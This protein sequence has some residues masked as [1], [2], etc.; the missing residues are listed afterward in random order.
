MGPN[1]R[2]TDAPRA[3]PAKAHAEAA[4]V[5]ARLMA[6]FDAWLARFDAW[7]IRGYLA[8]LEADMRERIRESEELREAVRAWMRTL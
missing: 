2:A 8:A 7:L 1:H 5:S 6:R 3:G 4:E